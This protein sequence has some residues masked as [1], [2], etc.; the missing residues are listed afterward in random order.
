MKK[1]LLLLY[2]ISTFS[3]AQNEKEMDSLKK[4]IR[5]NPQ[6]KSKATAYLELSNLAAD[7]DTTFGYINKAIQFSKLAKDY[8]TLY[9]SIIRKSN[10][11]ETK[12][13]TD[14]AILFLKKSL[15]EFIPANKNYIKLHF[16]IGIKLDKKSAP[17]SAKIYVNKG[18]KL[19]A[20]DKNA[21]QLVRGYMILGN[22]AFYKFDYQAAMNDYLKADSVC[23]RTDSLRVSALRAKTYNYIGYAVRKPYGYKE[24]LKYY[25]KSKAMYQKLKD[26]SGIQEI[27]IGLAQLYIKEKKFNEALPLVN[28]AVAYQ[29]ETKGAAYGY[30]VITRGYLYVK[31]KRFAE[32]EKDY[33]EY[34]RVALEKKEKKFEGKALGYLGYFYTEKKEYAKADY[35]YKKSLD[36]FDN[37]YDEKKR[38]L[39][40]EMIT[41]YTNSKDVDNLTK[42]YKDYIELRDTIEAQNKNKDLFELETKYQTEKKEQ[43]ISLL[44]AQNELAKKQKY[45]YIAL[46]AL[47]A[48]I[49][50]SLLYG[51]RN[52]I[53]TARKLNELNELKSRFFANISHEFRTPLTLIKSPVQSLQSSLKE[54]SQQ[55]QLKLIDKNANRMLEL[56]D[57]L[58]EL[59]KIDS[60]NLKLI[61]KDGNISTFLYAIIEPFDFQAKEKGINFTSN[62]G[63]THKNSSFDKDV[64]E[65]I[66]S[67]LVSNAIKYTTQ[68]ESVTFTSTVTDSH[69][70]LTVS[71]SGS[72]LRKEDLPRL[73]ERFYQKN[74]SQQGVGIG[75]A[76]VKELVD[77]YKGTITAVL[78][79]GNLSFTVSLPLTSANENAVVIP[80]GFTAVPDVV[81]GTNETELPILL[82]VDD[83]PEIRT[84]LKEIFRNDYHLLEAI[85]GKEALELAQKEI[86][87]CIISDVMMP[88]LDGYEFTKKIKSNELT[89]FIPIV[90]L[91][92]K[93]SDEAHIEGLK[94]TADVFLTKPFNNEVVRETVHQLITERKKLHTRYSQ[95]LILKPVDIVINSVEEKFIKKLQDIL[96]K[97]LSDSEYTAE[98]FA[99]EI[100]MSRMQLHRKLKSLLGVSATEF[101][102]NERLKIA[103]VLLTKSSGNISDVAYAVGFNDL[104]YFSKCFKEMYHCT[105]TEYIENNPST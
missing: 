104:S 42:T 14:A 31:M 52:K 22:I 26:N 94:S 20:K 65:K 44:S 78:E 9:S 17:D 6:N 34:Y 48:L 74:Q 45:I 21:V 68:N 79:K 50:G 103:A 7:S 29:K 82:I 64:V 36:Y 90:L 96:D 55:N 98:N 16:E 101:L 70:K 75:L 51:Y 77:L 86:P 63:K 60:G 88:N 43:Q 72:D 58:L 49:G 8:E 84:I 33:L 13:G 19:A 100:G 47:L 40:E 80:S 28:E 89:S 91:T 61:F 92:A 39:Y 27:N 24:T 15:P 2:F 54:D 3:F 35:Y 81:A 57:Q 38:E 85:D 69:L 23:E 53:K 56:V 87:D 73:F 25:L 5:S 105:P 83:N 11:I 30:A 97:N 37:K 93:T 4:I 1:A 95:E 10:L 66:V 46:L 18:I 12:S 62:I 99:S 102:R 76:L 59:S 67:N 41:L 71:N 32:A